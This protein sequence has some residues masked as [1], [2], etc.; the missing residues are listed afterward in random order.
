LWVPQVYE[1]LKCMG[2][3]QDNLCHPYILSTV[4]LSDIHNA[5]DLAPSLHTLNHVNCHCADD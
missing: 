3:M 4:V 2:I 1:N 5:A